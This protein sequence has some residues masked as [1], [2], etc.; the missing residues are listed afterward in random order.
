MTEKTNTAGKNTAGKNTDIR[1][2]AFCSVIIGLVFV[3]LRLTNVIEW[4]WWAVSAP[5]WS[6][7]SYCILYGTV[8][9][10]LRG[11]AGLTGIL[12][13]VVGILNGV[14]VFSVLRMLGVIDWGWRV[15]A[16]PLWVGLGLIALTSFGFAMQRRFG[17]QKAKKKE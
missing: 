6:L 12:N 7:I 3:V 1:N 8:R 2:S 5:F 16:I 15:I 13:G 11:C 17:G 4:S 10:L 14:V 9:G